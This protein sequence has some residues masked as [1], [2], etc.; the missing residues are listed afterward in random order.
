[1]FSE[2][3]PK[4]LVNNGFIMVMKSINKKWAW[5]PTDEI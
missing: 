4:R 3:K 5:L 1:M 2:T